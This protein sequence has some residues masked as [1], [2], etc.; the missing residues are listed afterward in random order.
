VT[1]EADIAAEHGP[2]EP[3][4]ADRLIGERPVPAARFRGAL[5][6]RLA[7]R[8]PG[9]GPRPERLRLH[10]VAYIGTGSLLIAVGALTATGVL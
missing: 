6:R 5:A 2:G 9:Y 1:D 4:M 8:D 7:G 10:V 3:E